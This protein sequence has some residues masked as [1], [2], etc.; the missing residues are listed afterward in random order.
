ML[1]RMVAC[2]L[3]QILVGIS[4]VNHNKVQLVTETMI[5]LL[6]YLESCVNLPTG[7]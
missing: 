7:A 1:T 2:L 5:E 3:L 6:F 4:A